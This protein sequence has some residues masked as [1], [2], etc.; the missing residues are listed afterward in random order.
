MPS[1][2]W[3]TGVWVASS[4]SVRKVRP[5]DTMYTG[6]SRS[7]SAR[8]CTGEVWVRSTC[9]DPSGAT[10]NVSCSLRAGM[11]GREVERVEVELLGLD[12]GSLGQ[13]PPHRDEDVGD[14]VGQDRDGVPGA[15]RLRAS[16]AA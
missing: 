10:W 9:R 14:V 13:L 5:I 3:K 2:W 12:L 15:D 8:I 7:S 16:T 4:S 11:V 6:S 1:T